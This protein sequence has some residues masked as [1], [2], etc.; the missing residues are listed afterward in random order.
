MWGELWEDVK[1]FYNDFY[2]ADRTF[3]VIQAIIPPSHSL[4]DMEEWVKD[5]FSNVKNKKYG[6]QNFAIKADSQPPQKVPWNVFEE[7]LGEMIL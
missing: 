6:L 7:S 4:D 2:S 5:S 1:A 3:V